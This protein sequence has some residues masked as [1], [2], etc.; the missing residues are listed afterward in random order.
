[1]KTMLSR[2][3]LALLWLL[4]LLP[5]PVLRRWGRHRPPVSTRSPA[6]GGGSR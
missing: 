4:H 6:S 2:L 3:L 5:L 1:M